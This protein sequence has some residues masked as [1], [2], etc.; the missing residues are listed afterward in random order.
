MLDFLFLV[1]GFQGSYYVECMYSGKN[2][3]IIADHILCECRD[4][5]NNLVKIKLPVESSVAG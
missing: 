5:V 4:S 3:R 1:S 2:L